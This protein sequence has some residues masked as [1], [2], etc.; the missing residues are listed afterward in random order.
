MTEPLRPKA[1]RRKASLAAKKLRKHLGINH[2]TD[3]ALEIVAHDCGLD[4]RTAPLEGTQAMLIRAGDRGHILVRRGLRRVER[5]FAIAHEIG[6][7]MLHRE[8]SFLGLCTGEIDLVSYRVSHTEEEADAFASEL[9]LP[10][11]LVLPTVTTAV[12]TWDTVKAVSGEFEVSLTAAAMRLIS[13]TRGAVALVSAYGGTLQWAK[14][15]FRWKTPL[16]RRSSVP[17]GSALANAEARWQDVP[18]EVDAGLWMPGAT[19]TVLEH[20]FRMP[21][22]GVVLALLS[23][24]LPESGEARAETVKPVP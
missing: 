23:H 17:E 24:S 4:V 6:H 16:P 21:A 19:G 3:L 2:P 18:A 11:Q 14:R 10:R 9:L 22:R 20:C 7:A 12:A 8:H 13:L 5:R 1:D 15:S